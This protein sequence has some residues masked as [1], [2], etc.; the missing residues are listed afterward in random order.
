MF[1]T[2]DQPNALAEALYKQLITETTLNLEQCLYLKAASPIISDSTTV[3]SKDI[4]QKFQNTLI[5]TIL[6]PV[7]SQK[8]AEY[9]KDIWNILVELIQ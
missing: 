9:H 6:N 2:P 1:S 8:K 4:V 7:D 3:Y 5:S